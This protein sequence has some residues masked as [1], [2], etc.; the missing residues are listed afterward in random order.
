MKITKK[1][2][3]QI[4]REETSRVLSENEMEMTLGQALNQSVTKSDLDSGYPPIKIMG[5]KE[6]YVQVRKTDRGFAVDYGT[7]VQHGTVKGSTLDGSDANLEPALANALVSLKGHGVTAETPAK[8]L[9]GPAPDQST[10]MERF[11]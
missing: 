9:K 4:I 6:L 2:L 7:S 5:D 1:R 8:I 11:R 3:V 10:G